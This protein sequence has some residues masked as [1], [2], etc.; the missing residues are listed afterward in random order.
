[1]VYGRYRR[2]FRRRRFVRRGR[3]GRK[4]RRSFRRRGGMKRYARKIVSM[5]A[6]KKYQEYNVASLVS[7]I[8]NLW[9][10]LEFVP[11]ETGGASSSQHIGDK[12][13]VTSVN[14]RLTF[15]HPSHPTAGDY[16]NRLRV[17]FGMWDFGNRARTV[18]DLTDQ[19]STD[20][21]ERPINHDHF[22]CLKLKMLDK[23]F[24]MQPY[25]IGSTFTGTSHKVISYV[26]RFK[27]PIHMEKMPGGTSAYMNHTFWLSMISDSGT[28]PHP[29][30]EGGWL[31]FH[32]TDA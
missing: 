13:E 1:M 12:W 18:T 19:Y 6:E 31:T 14:L 25:T 8:S 20:A 24:T 26:H 4:G 15:L 2:S 28:E 16:Y 7:N 9:T 22:P 11:G 27:K 17:V 5:A 32:Y 23:R 10:E 21:L 29:Q 3:G 30:L